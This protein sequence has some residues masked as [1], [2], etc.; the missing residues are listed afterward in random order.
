MKA[1]AKLSVLVIFISL[2]IILLFLLQTKETKDIALAQDP[3]ECRK[4]TSYTDVEGDTTNPTYAYDPTDQL[5]P[6]STHKAYKISSTWIDSPDQ[7]TQEFSST[8]YSRI[9]T[10]NNIYVT[11]A[12]EEPIK[13]A[14]CTLSDSS[15]SCK[16][17]GEA[18]GWTKPT[19]AKYS[20]CA[21]DK[22]DLGACSPLTNAVE[23]S[24]GGC[25]MSP[26]GG[27][28]CGCE[29]GGCAGV[30]CGGGASGTCTVSG[31]CSYACQSGYYN[32]DLDDS[33]GCEA[34]S[35]CYN[36]TFQTYTFNLSSYEWDAVVGL[37]FCWEGKYDSSGGGSYAN[38]LW[39]RVTT[40][41]WV[42]W[43][44]ISTT[45]TTYC[46]YF[47]S[48]NK[49]QVYNQSSKLVKFAVR[50]RQAIDGYK[51]TLYADFAY[52]NVSYVDLTPPTYS[53]NSTNSTLAGSAV[54]HSLKWDDNTG[55]SGY[56]FGF[57]NCT[58]KPHWWN[59][60]WS[61]RKNITINNSA[62]SNSLNDY[63]VWI[64]LTYDQ[65]MRPN[66]SDIRFSWYNSS[67]NQEIEIPYWIEEKSDAEWAKVWI[68]VPYI[69]ANGYETV[70]V[71]YGNPLATNKSNGTA[72]FEFFDDF[73]ELNLSRWTD[74]GEN[75]YGGYTI[76]NGNLVLYVG[77]RGKLTGWNVAKRTTTQSK[78]TIQNRAIEIRTNMTMGGTIYD[79]TNYRSDSSLIGFYFTDLNGNRRG[80]GR[81]QGQNYWLKYNKIAGSESEVL[82]HTGTWDGSQTNF[83]VL[84]MAIS[85]STI[86]LLEDYELKTTYSDSFT[87]TS[88][89]NI[90]LETHVAWYNSNGWGEQWIDWIRIRKY[91]SS[92]PT[93][94][95]QTEEAYFIN[96]AWQAW[97]GNPTSAWSN[98]TK[99]IN[100]TIGCTIEWKVYANDTNNNWN[101]SEIYSY[102]VTTVAGYLEVI[103]HFPPLS[104]AISQNHTFWVNATVT[105]KQGNCGEVN[106]II[107]Y[108]SSSPLPDKPI[109]TTQGAKPFYIVD[110]WNN[111]LNTGITNQI[112][113]GSLSQEQTCTLSWLVNATGA[114]N[115]YW[116]IGVLF[117]SSLTEVQANHTANSTIYIIECM[118]SLSLAWT[119]IDFGQ[120][121]PDTPASFNPAPGNANKLYNIT[122]TG[123]CNLK[124][125][126]KGTDLQNAT[127]NSVIK[128]GNLTWSNYSSVYDPSYIYSLD[129]SYT[130]LSSSL[131]APNSNLTTYYWLAVPPVYPGKYEGTITIC[132]NYSSL[133]D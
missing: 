116:K 86:K 133:C 60:Y 106:G 41:S 93:Y 11:T 7:A 36:Y 117:N 32:C 15:Y 79:A 94:S 34:S 57:S 27:H 20:A 43:Q 97:P 8:D 53:L 54:L 88:T 42:G 63:Q 3:Q 39:F 107:R 104:Y 1:I 127:L 123:T 126:I 44:T 26:A 62:N 45:E 122:N 76:E 29:M 121:I 102:T 112:S 96:D 25:T 33:N 111:S 99:M 125:W 124:L 119:S 40:S 13:Y 30:D 95:I 84:S 118:E 16:N 38:L 58:Q 115:S 19:C 12:A 28:S 71:Y 61:Y 66:F 59:K 120:L 10:S 130:L 52:L 23:I 35:P 67:S 85:G 50:G 87:P 92:E 18:C 91:A 56:I 68:K 70:Y 77:T 132:G 46:I 113:C 78:Y 48:S 65:D 131:L 9:G 103:L 80:Y 51:L 129:Y 22:C 110:S 6:N 5:I 69:R 14:G 83:H 55:L 90:T 100:S 24:R 128:V 109:N 82:W 75:N 64:N 114:T 108:N 21:S 2:M 89:G 31:T 98:V 4:P 49:T 81:H 72:V 74:P 37:K 101:A 105:C 17:Q 47:D 73:N